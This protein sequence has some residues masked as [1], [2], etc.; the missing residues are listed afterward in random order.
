MIFLYLTEFLKKHYKI[1]TVIITIIPVL[2][3]RKQTKEAK[4]T[5]LGPQARKELDLP[6]GGEKRGVGK[7]QRD[8]GGRGSFW[9]QVL[10]S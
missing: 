4:I 5:C 1:D 2:Q 6:G 7:M 9:L 10:C 8:G 3:M